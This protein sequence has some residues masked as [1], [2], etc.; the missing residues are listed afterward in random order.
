MTP[1][2]GINVRRERTRYGYILHITGKRANGVLMT[3][4]LDD[5]ELRLGDA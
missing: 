1:R 3:T 2:A 4:V 5:I